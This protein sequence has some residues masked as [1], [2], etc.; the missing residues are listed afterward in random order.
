LAHV[1]KTHTTFWVQPKNASN[2]TGNWLPWGR[3]DRWAVDSQYCLF[4]DG[5][6]PFKDQW[7]REIVYSLVLGNYNQKIEDII[8]GQ[9]A[10]G[11]WASCAAVACIIFLIFIITCEA[12]ATALEIWIADMA[13]RVRSLPQPTPSPHIR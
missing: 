5:T 9:W 6:E 11:M 7:D 13:G 1:S 10:T 8:G 12:N 3:S 2:G 4:S